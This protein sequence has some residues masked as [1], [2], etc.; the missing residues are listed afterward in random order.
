M[1][2][3]CCHP[4]NNAGP[5]PTH[6][7]SSSSVTPAGRPVL[8]K[9]DQV[10][11]LRTGDAAN[12]CA[13]ARDNLLLCGPGDQKPMVGSLVGGVQRESA[14]VALGSSPS[15][16]P[17]DTS[18]IYQPLALVTMTCSATVMCGTAPRCTASRPAA[19][20]VSGA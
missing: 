11:R 18:S 20:A 9:E 17:A 3:R 10:T 14:A 6:A 16:R 19:L 2:I 5:Q 1:T 4:I 7:P 12:D 13:T 15:L 8:L